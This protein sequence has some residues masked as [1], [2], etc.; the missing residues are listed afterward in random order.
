[1]GCVERDSVAIVFKKK[2]RKQK[3][4][5]GFSQYS[6]NGVQGHVLFVRICTF[7]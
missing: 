1:M 7:E 6:S 3:W 4:R 5:R 2:K